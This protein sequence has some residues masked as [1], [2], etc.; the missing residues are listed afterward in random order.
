MGT[1]MSKKD[2]SPAAR[3][4]CNI[5]NER[6]ECEYGGQKP[7][8]NHPI[9]IMGSVDKN[10]PSQMNPVTRFQ[11]FL[12]SETNIEDYFGEK[13]ICSLAKDSSRHVSGIQNEK[14]TVDNHVSQMTSL[15]MSDQE[16]QI[17]SIVTSKHSTG[18]KSSSSFSTHLIDLAD[19][20]SNTIS[21][22][23]KN[24]KSNLND[25]KYK[26]FACLYQNCFPFQ[27]R[28]GK[29]HC[30]LQFPEKL[31]IMLQASHIV[32]L[33]SNVVSWRMCGQAFSVIDRGAFVNTI[34]RKYF[35]Q[36]K[37]SSFQR[38][39]RAYGFQNCIHGKDETCHYHKIFLR[40]CPE[41][42]SEIKRIGVKKR[43]S[44]NISNNKDWQYFCDL[45]HV[46]KIESTETIN[47][48][49]EKIEISKKISTVINET[50]KMKI[51][52]GTEKCPVEMLRVDNSTKSVD[53]SKR[54]CQTNPEH[55][56]DNICFPPK[57][58]RKSTSVISDDS[59]AHL[60]NGS[61]VENYSYSPYSIIENVQ[62]QTKPSKNNDCSEIK[63]ENHIL[64]EHTQSCSQYHLQLPKG[65]LK[66][67]VFSKN[68]I[69]ASN[70]VNRMSVDSD[71]ID[72]MISDLF[73][74]KTPFS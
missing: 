54:N 17:H 41:L 23:S 69:N 72:E 44:A 3:P 58:H 1:I 6:D 4:N 18:S 61:Q 16:P 51:C 21:T 59:S 10:F 28:T 70:F 37:W 19:K 20:N 34:L 42:C 8:H 31:H 25:Q 67:N 22:S 49:V 7:M 38:Q 36:T 11:N 63:Q 2:H 52:Q 14:S 60:Q 55:N 47:S 68:D 29:G 66:E 64:L 32:G 57:S 12:S 39:L 73:F 26:G 71:D 50:K 40:E 74:P 45:P 9:K 5:P 15:C 46:E 13:L 43:M 56:S 27:K 35:K 62:L 65:V 33:N 30:G 53:G 48:E 24:S